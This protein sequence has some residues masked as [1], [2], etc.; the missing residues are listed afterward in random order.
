MKKITFSILVLFSVVSNSFAQNDLWRNITPA[1]L[2]SKVG[3]G[4]KDQL[5]TTF[6][7][8]NFNFEQVR[9]ALLQ[10]PE[11]SYQNFSSNVI[12]SFPDG[13]GGFESFSMRRVYYMDKELNNEYPDLQSY[14]GVGVDNP[15]NKIHISLTSADFYGVITGKKTVYLDAYKRGTPNYIIAYDRK[16]YSRQQDDDFSCGYQEEESE[17]QQFGK[18]INETFNLTDSRMRTYGIA[19]ACTSEYSAY[20]GNTIAG[21]LAAMNVTITRVNSVFERDLGVRFQIV[22]NNNRLVYINGVNNQGLA[23]P[24]DNYSG[25]QMLSANT[26]NITARIGVANYNIGHVFSTGGGGIAGTNPCNDTTKGRGVTGIVTPE[27]DPFDIDYVAH[28]I[29]HQFGAGHTYYNACFGAKVGD[30]FEPGSA[31][32]I[33]GYAGICPPNVQENSDAYFHARSIEQMT[34]LIVNHTCEQETVLANQPPFANAGA[35]YTIPRNTPFILDGS[36]SSD[37]NGDVLT[38]CWEQYN[39]NN[40]GAQPPTPSNTAGPVFRSVM[41][42]TDPTRTFPNL[43]AIINNVTPTW[44]VLPNVAR[45]MNFRLTVRDNNSLVGQTRNANMMVTVNNSGPFVISSPNTGSELWYAG[46]TKTVTWNVNSTNSLSANVNIKLSTDGGYTYPITLVSNTPNDGAQNITVPNVV[47]NR[48]RI[49]I[50]AATNIFFDI[51]NQDFE[52]KKGT[53]DFVATD[54]TIPVCK[55]NTASFTFAYEKAPDFNQTVTLALQNL[56]AGVTASFSPTTV[57]TNQNVTVT[58]T[59][60]GALAAGSYPITLRGTSASAN[61]TTAVNLKVFEDTIEPVTLIAPANGAQNM[62]SNPEFQWSNLVSASSYLFEIATDPTFATTVE[63]ITTTATSY[64]SSSLAGGTVY[65]WRVRPINDCL[66]GSYSKI[67][68]IQIAEDVCRTYNNEYF[69]NN[70]NTWETNSNNAVSARVDVTD[71]IVVQDVSFYMR[72]T[73]TNINDIKMQFRAPDGK[74]SEVFNRDCSGAN[75]NVTFTDSGIPLTCGNVVPNVVAALEGNQQP[76]QLFQRFRGINAFGT[77]VLLATDRGAN[78]AGGTFNEYSVTVCGKLQNSNNIALTNLGLTVNSGNQATVTAARLTATQPG[79]TTAQIRYTVTKLPMYGQ[80]LFNGNRMFIGDSFTQA[81]IAANRISYRNNA[82]S[83]TNDTFEFSI[84][85]NQNT[86]IGGQVF[87]LTITPQTCTASTTWN[88][89]TWSNGLPSKT[90]SAVFNGNF[91]TTGTIEACSVQVNGTAVLTVASGSNLIVQNAVSIATTANIIVQNNANFIQVQHTPNTGL[92]TV[93]RNS[94]PA[95]RLDYTMWS[96][97]VSNQNLLAFSPQTLT[98]RFYVYDPLLGANGAY[99]AIVPNSNTFQEA[100]GYL[101][102]TPNNW[103]TPTPTVYNGSFRGVLTNALLTPVAK[104]GTTGYNLIGNPY[105]STI[106]ANDFILKNRFERGDI[107]QTIDGTLY[108][109]TH[110]QPANASGTYTASNYAKYTLLG[111]TAAVAGGQVP[112]GIIQVGQ[113]FMVNALVPSYVTFSNDMRIANNANQ[114]FRVNNEPLVANSNEEKHRIW[115]ELKN[116]NGHYSQILLGYMPEATDNYD[117]GIDGFDFG[118][119][120]SHIYALLNDNKLAINGRG[121]PFEETH[122]FPIG[123]K[124]AEAGSYEINLSDFDGIFQSNQN[125]YL[126][127][128]QNNIVHDLKNSSYLFDSE[129]FESGERF[130]IVFQNELSLPEIENNFYLQ[131]HQNENNVHIKSFNDTLE[132]VEVFDILGRRVLSKTEIK[133]ENF[134]MPIQIWHKQVL[135]FKITTTSNGLRTVKLITK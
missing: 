21:V 130:K 97:P 96:S 5:P 87:N 112:N 34:A 121:L 106:S 9:S 115:L 17:V 7:G 4:T 120:G 59:G 27:F 111:G 98:N 117:Y 105:A 72:A 56:P 100:K 131:I 61:E 135:I 76:S 45:T 38:Y 109:W 93:N 63:S 83:N 13:Y 37:P 18:T 64:V 2:Q 16:F 88:G 60:T 36:A 19:I 92:A 20:H 26:S 66:F 116:N 51:S 122:E 30:D 132:S 54:F 114:F 71:N 67:H 101:I 31:S 124:I 55:P 10:A 84:R 15:V 79:A 78:T 75:I 23:D 129:L 77:W 62:P 52:I 29:G 80:L 68:A 1:D 127:D 8:Y 126:K 3:K 118:T 86:L 42:T 81:D 35:N 95:I 125:I 44:E 82:T 25:N 107:N 46:E 70:D 65:F 99:T 32:T 50:E 24:Y 57:S 102:R 91:S 41:P 90:K 85:G 104:K 40:G 128:L 12:I 11:E 47:S 58:L 113:G 14:I 53:F 73:H 123:I 74:F 33:L 94:A 22:A 6:Y 28:E 69:E 103:P 89:S 49:K 39:N 108:F 133:N 43:E 134:Q 110:A 119:E 48:A